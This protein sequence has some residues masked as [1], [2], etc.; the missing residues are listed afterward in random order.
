MNKWQAS[1]VRKP[2][3]H[4]RKTNSGG[5]SDVYTRNENPQSRSLNGSG[6]QPPRPMAMRPVAVR[7][8]NQRRRA[9][10]W[11]TAAFSLVIA[12]LIVA[13]RHHASQA[14]AVQHPAVVNT[15]SVV[16]I[17]IESAGE[18]AR[19]VAAAGVAAA[20]ERI[21]LFRWSADDAGDSGGFFAMIL[22]G[23]E[24]FPETVQRAG[25]GIGEFAVKT[26]AWVWGCAM[27][28]ATWLVTRVFD[29][30]SAASSLGYHGEEQI[31]WIIRVVAATLL[32]LTATL[33]WTPLHTTWKMRHVSHYRSHG[34][35]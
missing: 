33:L 25:T 22:R 2:D 9:A 24:H 8:L 17:Q 30:E 13:N 10:R 4:I 18:Q 26:V 29:L 32:V 12:L 21:E 5:L 3:A 19:G 28:V 16:S 11:F 35:R 14:G 15:Q 6:S 31:D 7:P 20:Q 1:F 23:A 27:L 34:V